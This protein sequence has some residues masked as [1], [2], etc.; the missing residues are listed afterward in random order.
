MGHFAVNRPVSV[1]M[2]T[3]VMIM[4]GVAAYLNLPS[5]LFPEVSQPGLVV[6]TEYKGAASSEIEKTVTK[7][8]E[9][10]LG[11]VKNVA[12]MKSISGEERSDIA[13]TFGWGTNMDLAAMDVRAK[14]DE[15][16][17]D[18]PEDA[19][20]PVVLRTSSGSGAVMV[21]NIAPNPKASVDVRTNPDDLREDVERLLKP[22]LERING[23]AAIG[24]AGGKEYEVRVLILP[25]KLSGYNLS[26]IDVKDAFERENISQ[27]GGKLK[28]ENSQFLIRT[29]GTF[30]INEIGELV[31]SRPGEKIVRLREVATFKSHEV[32]KS[33]ESVARLKTSASDKSQT[34][35]EVSIF[36][37]S[38]GNSVAIC[39][40]VRQTR[41]QVLAELAKRNAKSGIDIDEETVA[42]L[43]TF[44]S[45]LPENDPAVQF[46]S[47][48]APFE[49][50]VSYDES[51][52]IS[53]SL[54][55]VQ[56]NGLQ[57]L[58]LA[59]VILLVFLRRVQSTFIVVLS[60]PVSVIATFSLFYASGISVNI[61][62]MAGLTLAVGMVV[63]NAIVVT[64]AI[65]HKLTYE[66]RIK[67]AV[68][69]AVIE[70]GPAVWAST[71]TT[72]AVFLPIV[73][74]PGIAGQIFRDLSWVITYTLIFSIIIAFTLI[75]MLTL[76]V[77]GI[78]F[79][80]FDI[81]N[82]ILE[83]LISPLTKVADIFI[84]IYKSILKI[85][86]ESLAARGVLVAIMAVCFVGAVLML[87]PSEFF[88]ETKVDS[89]ALTVRPRVG[90]TLEVVNKAAERIETYFN[91]VPEIVR[92]NISATPR[93][94]RLIATFDKE[95][96]MGG[97]VRPV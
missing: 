96:V 71:L 45:S 10:K 9:E 83:T 12:S 50:V 6:H 16:M 33:P 60:M 13:L 57:G 90:Q 63:D 2:L 35:I 89:F 31:V 29:V 14:L 1:L 24:I 19:E 81:L 82:K 66:K 53:E 23:V 55:M 42:R 41:I 79:G 68:T 28:E 18:L 48:N 86:I 88:P 22:R 37:K 49:A 40:A 95:K 80:L 7:K 43:A 11:S 46:I 3:L 15:V 93:E 20:D 47:K 54:D 67:K 30:T 73:F 5:D 36:K 84:G 4:F 75:P 34:S 77:M 94:I 17:D 69:E 39:E 72:V 85:F 26:I 65:F 21:L 32:E 70:I 74:V 78:E 97:E 25:D 58:I 27:R 8:L 61:F 92:F 52:F 59:S 91:N 64:E 76:Q 38:G 51:V 56:S 87:P 44:R 62:S